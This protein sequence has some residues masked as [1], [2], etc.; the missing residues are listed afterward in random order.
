LRGREGEEIGERRRRGVPWLRRN[1]PWKPAG[2]RSSGDKIR[3]P[4]GGISRERR[5][6]ME[7]R[8]RGFIGWIRCSNYCQETDEINRSNGDSFGSNSG[9]GF[10]WKWVMTGGVQASAG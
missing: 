4:G 7:R 6:E 8:E 9:G 10:G 5:G 1:R 3:Q 2:A